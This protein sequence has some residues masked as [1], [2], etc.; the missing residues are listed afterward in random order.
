MTNLTRFNGAVHL[1]VVHEMT[2]PEIINMIKDVG[3]GEF[4]PSKG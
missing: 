3:M 2:E 4:G 1:Y